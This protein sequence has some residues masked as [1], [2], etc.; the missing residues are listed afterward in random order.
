MTS[1]LN[2]I[3]AAVARTNKALEVTD[4][5]SEQVD[6]GA[7][8]ERGASSINI[9]TQNIIFFNEQQERTREGA[10]KVESVWGRISSLLKTAAAAFSIQKIITLADTMTLTE[11]RLNLIND[12][13]Q[14]TA[15]LQDKILAA[16][17]RSRTSYNAMADAVAKLGTL[18]GSAFSSNE[19]MIAFVE[20]MNKN[21][22]IGGAS[23][24]EQTAAM[25][26]LTQAMAAGRLQGDEFRSIMEN[27]PLLAQA[28][29]DYMGKT[30]GELRELSSEGLITADII[31]KA[32]FAAAEETNKRFAE[33]P[34]TFSQVGTIVANT[35]L[36]TFQPVI[37]M[38]GQGAQF[39]YDNWSTIE[40]IFWGLVAA[41]GAYVVITTIW[42]AV[43][44]LQVAANRALL[45]SMLTNPILWIAIAIGVVI[46]LIYKWVESV[47]GLR[48]AWL[49]VCNALLTAWDWVQIGFMT[50]VY[51]VMDML[52]K[53]QLAFMTAG[54]N[55]ANFMGDMK[56]NVLMILQNMVNGAISIINGFISALNKIPG[57]S[58][59]LIQEVTFGT[60]AQLENEAAKQA[61]AQGL[62]D[63]RS[64]IESKIAERDAKLNQMKT[65]ARAATAQRQAE[66]ATA[67]AEAANKKAAESADLIGK[68]T[69]DIDS[70]GTGDI[71][72]VGTGDIDSVGTVGEVGKIKE[73][74]NIAEED[75][76]FLRD[77]A[78]MR[79]VQNF[80]TLT[81]TVA[82][83]AKISE[84]V[85]VDEVIN[86][87]ETK[88]EDEFYAAAE[89]VYA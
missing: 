10:R 14:T 69:G 47:G 71:D 79:Y 72:S 40:P 3:T 43:T 78:E 17:N 89:G 83:D 76:K 50:G 34:M 81:P 13:L 24:Q 35:M 54:V 31:K 20:L 25:Y 4:R 41:V 15:Q 44:W 67:K 39:I 75:L 88:L 48:I 77:V 58:I 12:G 36:Q 6:P 29:A 74:V 68:F 27:A 56:A 22:V 2:K 32:M 84:K 11:A 7:G 5:L 55:I 33:M 16:A 63:Y 52:N 51:W 59:D 86:R 49:I 80:V 42:T 18:A 45:A 46:G 28:I 21:F 85:D 73:D 64:Q 26:Q 23:I 82:V 9:A 19:E 87:I 70:V 66:I 57:V 65:D 62:E 8:F 38:I 1:A 60:T 53:L 30:T 37:Q 61:R